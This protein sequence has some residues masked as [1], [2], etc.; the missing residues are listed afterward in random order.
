MHA[1]SNTSQPPRTLHVIDAAGPHWCALAAAAE[2]IRV[3]AA[4]L[5]VAIGANAGAVLGRVG[6]RLCDPSLRATDGSSGQCAGALLPGVE[7]TPPL[8][9]PELAWPALRRVTRGHAPITA[10]HAWSLR[11]ASAV[12]LARPGIPLTIHLH[13]LPDH[14]RPRSIRLLANAHHIRILGRA[15][16]AA[17]LD[18]GLP[19]NVTAETSEFPVIH[20][21]IPLDRPAARAARREEWGVDDGTLV[22]HAAG[23][24]PAAVG[25]FAESYIAGVVRFTGRETVA[26]APPGARE[27]ERAARIAHTHAGEWRVICDPRPPWELLPGCDLALHIDSRAKSAAARSLA[28]PPSAAPLLYAAAM[29]VPIVA[30]DSP[31]VRAVLAGANAEATLVPESDFTNGLNY[32]R[33]ILRAISRTGEL[34]HGAP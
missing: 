14:R 4:P 29:G 5:I 33:A 18:A 28:V 10:I 11:A 7:V 15:T 21:L 16:R 20:A 12:R 3:G 17:W 22:I 2:F 9:R 31:E 27:L 8:A 30:Q 24:P 1:P 34:A 25:A 32:S 23:E 13:E 19:I 6:I 26:I